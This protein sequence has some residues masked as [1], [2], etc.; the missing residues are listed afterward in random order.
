MLSGQVS[1]IASY[2]LLGYQS[3]QTMDYPAMNKKVL[4]TG[5]TG[6]VGKR[7]TEILISQGCE[8]SYLS[9]SK[10]KLAG[11][12]V[13]K[14]DIKKN[15]IE[16]GA[17]EN[18]DCI[19]HLAGAGVA[20]RRWSKEYKDVIR[21]SRV[22]SSELLL[23]ALKSSGNKVKTFI[24]A[25]AIGIYGFDTGSG[26]VSEESEYGTDFLAHVTR[27]WEEKVDQVVDL[28]KRLVKLR[29]G[30][31][32]SKDGGALSKMI[33]PAKLGLGAGF[34]SGKQYL[35]WIHIDDLCAMFIK[36]I[37]SDDLHGS[38]NAV[39]PSPI[40]NYEFAKTLS[41]VLRRPF[42]APNVP[43]FL[44][45]IVLGEMANLVLGGSK[46]SSKKIE[47]MGFQFKFRDLEN[48]II[49]LLKK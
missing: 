37:E 14:W 12:S 42:F 33:G 49:D 8:V 44:L 28:N 27:E 36:A 2:I 32:L 35:S 5:G 25:S 20:E 10:K 18:I 39:A 6:L 48:A 3:L 22:N 19:I 45:K 21:D 15:F 9:R 29:I 41:K 24:S 34:G 4:I 40:T 38:Y 11:V 46:V 7:L 1:D 26:I 43:G 16:E 13:F 30:M 17:L 47:S 23:Q 31:V